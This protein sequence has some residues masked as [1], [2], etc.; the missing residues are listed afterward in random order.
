MHVA[1][2]PFEEEECVVV[3]EHVGAAVEPVEGCYVLA[4]GV[5]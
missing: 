3:D 4:A 1:D 5:V 2:G